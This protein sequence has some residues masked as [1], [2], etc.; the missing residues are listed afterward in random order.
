VLIVFFS[1]SPSLTRPLNDS[2]IG[3]KPLGPVFL[4]RGGVVGAVSLYLPLNNLSNGEID[5]ELCLD[6]YYIYINF[7]KKRNRFQLLI[8]TYS[9]QDRIYLQ[10]EGY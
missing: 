5:L 1:L 3:V 9:T 2:F 4:E 8:K 6:I 10:Y 7:Y